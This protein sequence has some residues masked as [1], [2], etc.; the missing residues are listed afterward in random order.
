MVFGFFERLHR[1]TTSGRKLL[2]Q[3]PATVREA[4]LDVLLEVLRSEVFVSTMR[5]TKIGCSSKKTGRSTSEGG[6]S[7]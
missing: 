2:N 5:E 3:L 7:W 1:L 6:E 4:P